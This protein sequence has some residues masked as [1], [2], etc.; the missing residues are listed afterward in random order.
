MDKRKEKE[1]DNLER[2]VNRIKLKDLGC[3]IDR[4]VTSLQRSYI[5]VNYCYEKPAIISS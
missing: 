4:V 2:A 5:K 1:L 3:D